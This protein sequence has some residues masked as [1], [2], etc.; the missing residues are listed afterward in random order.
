MSFGGLIVEEAKGGTS[1]LGGVWRRFVGRERY[2]K[3][4]G[5][6]GDWVRDVIRRMRQHGDDVDRAMADKIEQA[7]TNGRLQG[8]IISTPIEATKVIET[9]VVQ[10]VFDP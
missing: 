8:L 2:L 4:M 10:V 7:L 5:S 3:Q 1:R 9:K 6:D